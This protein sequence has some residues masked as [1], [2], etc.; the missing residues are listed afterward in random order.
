MGE[1]LA[2]QEYVAKTSKP[3]WYFQN[4]QTRTEIDFIFDGLENVRGVVPMEVKYGTNLRAKSLASFAKKH[5]PELALRVSAAPYSRRRR[6]REHTLLRSWIGI[7]VA[8]GRSTPERTTRD[9]EKREVL[10]PGSSERLDSIFLRYL[11]GHPASKKELVS[12]H[13]LRETPSS[14]R[15]KPRKPS[16]GSRRKTP[17]KAKERD[18]AR[19][20]RYPTNRKTNIAY[21][22]EKDRRPH[23]PPP[24]KSDCS[25][26][27]RRAGAK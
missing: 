7:R 17:S 9:S 25:K 21:T 10:K 27:W 18:A 3:I 1:Q 22:K 11:E 16:R 6:D 26:P 23:S 2:L 14:T 15:A 13:N 19:I 12:L 5:E 8:Y 24:R 4:E 20:G